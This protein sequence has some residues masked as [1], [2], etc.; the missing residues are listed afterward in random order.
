MYLGGM[1]PENS[2]G[3]GYAVGLKVSYILIKHY[4]FNSKAKSPPGDHSL[5][6]HFRR[7]LFC[8]SKYFDCHD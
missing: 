6:N 8:E 2:N 5:S 7:R 1:A 3:A 4:T